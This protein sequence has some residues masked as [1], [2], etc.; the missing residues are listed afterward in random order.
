MAEGGP[1]Q[2]SNFVIYKKELDE[3]GKA[4]LNRVSYADGKSEKTFTVP[5]GSYVVHAAH[6]NTLGEKEITI[7]EGTRQIVQIILKN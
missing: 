5:A 2:V 7:A 6:A 4:K 1:V 3:F